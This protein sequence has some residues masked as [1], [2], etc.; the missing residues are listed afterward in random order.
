[1]IA[2]ILMWLHPDARPNIDWVVRD[3]GQGPFIHH[4]DEQAIGAP[5]PTVEEVLAHEDA[6]RLDTAKQAKIAAID[7]RSH[8]LITSGLEVASEKK[9]STSTE[10][11]INFLA[12]RDAVKSGHLSPPQGFSTLDGGE[13]I[14]DSEQRIE[15]I[16]AMW[17]ARKKEILD[18]GR[19]LREAV[20][21]A[22]S[23]EEV[24]AV[25]DERT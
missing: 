21:R 2:N 4:W 14:I 24:E 23:L 6:W 8:E 17:L 3:D 5:Q 11:Q 15:E 22:E 9:I 7:A 20:L 25:V 19:F 1:M 13:Y 16:Y 10:A 12:F 18:G